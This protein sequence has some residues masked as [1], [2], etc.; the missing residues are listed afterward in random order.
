MILEHFFGVI[1]RIQ[2]PD[3]ENLIEIELDE[4]MSICSTMH[5]HQ[6]IHN[7]PMQ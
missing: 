6:L 3:S 1:F 2:I 5:F 7:N 4:I